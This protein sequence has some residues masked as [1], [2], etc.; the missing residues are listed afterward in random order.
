V[1]GLDKSTAALFDF[2]LTPCAVRYNTREPVCWGW[3]KLRNI[4]N[5]STSDQ[6]QPVVVNGF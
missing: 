5:G 2:R 1:K 3:G 6:K 4:G